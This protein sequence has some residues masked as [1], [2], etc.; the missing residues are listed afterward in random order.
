VGQHVPE[1]QRVVEQQNSEDDGNWPRQLHDVQQS[2][3]S[4]L[5]YS[6]EMQS[7]G[8]FCQLHNDTA[9]AGDNEIPAGAAELRFSGSRPQWSFQFQEP[10][11]RECSGDNQSH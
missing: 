4:L 11:Q 1:V 8:T 2:P 10:Q 9:D 3:A 7:N 6:G 5:H